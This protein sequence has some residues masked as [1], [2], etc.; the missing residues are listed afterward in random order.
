MIRLFSI[1]LFA[2]ALLFSGHAQAVITFDVAQG[3]GNVV[4]SISDIVKEGGEKLKEVKKKYLG[5]T[6]GDGTEG[7]KALSK[8]KEKRKQ[9]KEAKKTLEDAKNDPRVKAAQASAQLAAVQK[10]IKE[11]ENMIKDIN[12]A[13]EEDFAAVESNINGQIKV[14]EDNNVTLRGMIAENPAQA[15]EL[16]NYIAG[17]NAQISALQQLLDQTREQGNNEISQ[18]IAPLNEKLRALKQQQRKLAN[19]LSQYVQDSLP[20]SADSGEVLNAAA[21]AV[22]IAPGDPED[23][24]AIDRIRRARQLE[25]RNQLI[26]NLETIAA[27]R[28][29]FEPL[30]EETQETKLSGDVADSAAGNIGLNTA[31]KTAVVK[32]FYNYAKQQVTTLKK[33][34]AKE[35]AASAEFKRGDPER[36]IVTFNLDDYKYKLPKGVEG[37][38]DVKK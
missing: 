10:Q 20:E 3:A 2:A 16:E 5:D 38:A 22:F 37:C 36:D 26:N 1:V 4:T 14:Y 24:E 17:N 28:Q 31:V 13:N 19:E 25:R 6:M 9:Y 7:G 34:T 33:E 12:T 18:A 35:Y 27:L 15:E 23:V 21:D 11:T 8:I 30:A 32:F 29:E